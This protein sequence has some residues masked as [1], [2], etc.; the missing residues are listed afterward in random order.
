MSDNQHFYHTSTEGS[1]GPARVLRLGLKLVLGAALAVGA[2]LLVWNAKAPESLARFHG[3]LFG[4]QLEIHGLDL[5]YGGR[6]VRLAPGESMDVNPAVPLRVAGF[7]S[8]RW[9]D[10]DLRLR[11]PDADLARLI[12]APAS[13]EDLLGEDHFI[14]PRTIRLE[15]VDEQEAVAEF[16]L[17]AAF[18][19]G[20]WSAKAA[21]A[22]EAD[23]KIGYYHYSNLT[24]LSSCTHCKE[25]RRRCTAITHR[26]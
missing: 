13:L 16:G 18:S 9:R 1:D 19:A 25:R 7:A 2:A 14:E 11:S 20:D 8:N 22:V 12:G 23:A 5:D 26:M 4:G 10:Y 21:A 6:T 24:K 17:R 3:R 15:I